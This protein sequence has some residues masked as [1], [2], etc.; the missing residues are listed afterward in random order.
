MISSLVI[1]NSYSKSEVMMTAEDNESNKASTK[2]DAVSYWGQSQNTD[3]TILTVGSQG[4]ME[5]Q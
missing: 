2:L 3:T 5:L 1:T 4:K